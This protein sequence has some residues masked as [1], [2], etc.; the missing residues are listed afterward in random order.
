VELP[1]GRGKKAEKS[2]VDGR[3]VGVS[4]RAANACMGCAMRSGLALGSMET[5][6][7]AELGVRKSLGADAGCM[8]PGAAVE[9]RGFEAG[10]GALGMGCDSGSFGLVRRALPPKDCRDGCWTPCLQCLWPS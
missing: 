3:A 2:A 1:L 7:G 6:P 9:R 5:Y 4:H 8:F 10:L